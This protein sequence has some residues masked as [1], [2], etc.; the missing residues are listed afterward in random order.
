MT[1]LP[2]NPL[3][4]LS[5]LD[6]K[7]WV[8]T[9]STMTNLEEARYN[10]VY[11]IGNCKEPLPSTWQNQNDS[12]LEPELVTKHL[13][14]ML[15]TQRK[16]WTNKKEI[17]ISWQTRRSETKQWHHEI[18]S[19]KKM[20]REREVRTIVLKFSFSSIFCHSHNHIIFF[21]LSFFKILI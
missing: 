11:R 4:C 18:K 10:S 8:Q 19:R 12:A 17:N 6:P 14:N 3:P 21:C 5:H 7:Q 20:W 15:I 16:Y 2:E 13:L 9:K 1:S